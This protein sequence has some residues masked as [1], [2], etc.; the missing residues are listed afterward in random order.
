M[1]ENIKNI[2]DDFEEID[3]YKIIETKNS[4]EELFFVKKELDIARSKDVQ[5]FK[6]TVYKNFQEDD[7]KYKGSSTF[8]IH[9]S[10]NENE[11]KQAIK[12]NIFA[13]GFVK[14]QYYDLPINE[15]KSIDNVKSKFATMQ[16]SDWMPKLTEAL[17]INDKEEMGG[18]NSA[19]LFLDRVYT[20]IINSE[21]I[22]RNFESYKGMIEFI[23]VW[24]YDEEIELYKRLTFSDY[25][26]N[27]ISDTVKEMIF[28]AKERA[29]AKKTVASGK[30]KV[31][32][33]DEPVKE[34]LK[35]YV[36][37]TNTENIYNEMS[38]IKIGEW[39]QG[40]NIKGDSISLE[41]D[42]H[43]KNSIYSKPFDDN[44]TILSKVN[45]IKDGKLK[46]YHGDFRHSYYLNTKATGNIHNFKIK[47]GTKSIDDMKREEYV[48]LV[49]F[50]D[51]QLDSV[52][53]NFGGEIRLG[54]YFDGENTIPITGGSLSG[55]IN[56]IHSNIFLS[57]EL[58]IADGFIGPKAIEMF[59]L[60][61]AGE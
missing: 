30:Y 20:R 56:D 57:K 21:G 52:T 37:K 13:S 3:G 5:H 31:I 14:N 36:D 1:I 49:T 33:R 32:L 50:S 54:W 25:E 51:F 58:Q 24:K 8:D 61:I 12:D 11:I 34:I 60:S 45:I 9:P 47:S 35:Y 53:G 19:E 48:E 22:D 41:I 10:M 17:Y 4:S 59:N 18:I 46:M 38:N 15:N 27:V 26:P 29:K 23:T 2:L 39:I 44:G 43:M 7:K 16:L 55:N 42:P 40:D 28:L 6:V